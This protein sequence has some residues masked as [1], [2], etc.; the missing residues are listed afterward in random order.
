MDFA[1]IMLHNDFCELETLKA[2]DYQKVE[3]RKR[4][5][6]VNQLACTHNSTCSAIDLTNQR[7]QRNENYWIELWATFFAQ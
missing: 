1:K 5:Y 4:I 6:Y 3:E 7:P 2:F